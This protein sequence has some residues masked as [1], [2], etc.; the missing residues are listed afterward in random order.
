MKL[1]APAAFVLAQSL[2][3]GCAAAAQQNPEGKIDA[4][5][6]EI[7]PTDAPGL[8]V[9]VVRDGEV[10]LRKGYGLASLE[11]Q[12]PITSST[13][14]D[15]AS[16]SKQF[17]GLAVAMLVEQGRIQ[18]DDDIREYIPELPD[19]GRPITIDHLLHHTSGLRDWPATLAVAGWRMDDVIAFDQILTMAYNQE[20]LNFVPGSE[21]TY[22][23]TG[24]N[25][26]AELVARVTGQT[27]REWTD[28]HLF[29]PLG[30]ANT[31]FRDDHNEVIP[32][33]AYGY[34]RRGDS[35]Y[36]R[37]P[38]NLTALGSSSLFS[39]VDDLTKWV[40]NFDDP[41]VG[42]PAAIELMRTR[43]VLDDGSEISYAFGL[44]HGKHRG[45]PT[46]SHS[47]SWASFTSH[48]V[49]FPEQ[50]FG[51]IVLANNG[52][53]NASRAAYDVA[54]IFLE[55]E[56]APPERTAGAA[57]AAVEIAPSI[58]EDYVGTYRLGPGWYVRIS[59]D[60]GALTTRAT[61]EPEFPMTARSETEF[62]VEAYGAPIVFGRDDAGE[63]TH[64]EYR[65]RHAPRLER[66]AGDA[67]S[68]ARLEEF[69]GEYDSEELGTSYRIDAV[70][71]ALV[72]RHRRH[73]SIALT[74]AWQDDFS[75]SEW[76]TRSIEFE[77]DD[78]G[79]V[80]GFVVNAGERS[81]NIRFVKRP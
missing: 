79:V 67:G 27:F 3:L 63:V 17:T 4:L 5:F 28:E 1:A 41:S 56:L 38:D 11:H 69:V 75:G 42:G 44:S 72:M 16:V 20:S 10:V 50:R 37:V 39:T 54:D 13:V 49:H 26:L 12:V 33:R 62:W 22:S 66:G 35:G 34:A 40:L 55:A 57:T 8:A 21:Y 70:D 58:L 14:F 76:F 51:V 74:R 32:D 60:G 71:G 15:V 23:N 2:A 73:G 30:M 47:G 78:A 65:G 81:R 64:F 7:D 6:T 48:V 68:P 18:L 9:A 46:V 31:H 25:L 36:M 43:G 61:R 19:F 80:I 53:I 45:L 24:Y 29:R 52:S 77:R 59:L